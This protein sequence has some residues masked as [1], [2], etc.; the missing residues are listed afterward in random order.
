M[1]PVAM[2][3]AG[4]KRHH[5]FGCGKPRPIRKTWSSFT[6]SFGGH[7]GTA[8]AHS[9]AKATLTERPTASARPAK[10]EIGHE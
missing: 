3:A 8:I 7:P 1:L 10:A 2:F 9:P 5:R 6:N 4:R